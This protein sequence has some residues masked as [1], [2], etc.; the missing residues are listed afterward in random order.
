[1]LVPQIGVVVN[2]SPLCL[3]LV[4]EKEHLN[5]RCD[6]IPPKNLLY[7]R[8]PIGWINDHFFSIPKSERASNELEDWLEAQTKFL[9]HP[10]DIRTFR[11]YE[12]GPYFNFLISIVCILKNSSSRHR[13]LL[14][15]CNVGRGEGLRELVCQS[16]A[17]YSRTDDGYVLSMQHS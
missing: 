8:E 14:Y 5:W 1:M 15:Y 16:G 11:V 13:I 4:N 3:F 2:F 6:A 7:Y 17:T 9:S 10:L 12:R